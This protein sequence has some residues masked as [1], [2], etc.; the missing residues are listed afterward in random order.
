MSDTRRSKATSNE[1]QDP[2]ENYDPVDYDDPL[3]EA[4]ATQPVSAMQATP[5]ASIAPDTSIRDAV[6][7]LAGMHVACLLVED[8]Q[9]LLGVFTDRNVLDQVALEYDQL[10]HQPV[11]EVMTTNPVFVYETDSSAAVFTVMAVHGFRHVPVLTNDRK[12]AGIAS[13]HRI[14]SFLRDN[15]EG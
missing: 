12:I 11:S 5:Y 13:P 1:F 10:K 14:S 8:D 7:Q 9:K 15:F 2:L 3:E 6:R 4:L